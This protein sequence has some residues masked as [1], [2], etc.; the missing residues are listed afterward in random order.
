LPGEPRC[1]MSA[2]AALDHGQMERDS[3]ARYGLA[4]TGMGAWHHDPIQISLEDEHVLSAAERGE[5]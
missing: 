2:P 1:R 5:G 4:L 3:S